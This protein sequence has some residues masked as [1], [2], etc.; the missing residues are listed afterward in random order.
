MQLSEDEVITNE[1]MLRKEK[2]I[3]YT[4]TDDD[5]IKLYGTTGDEVG[6]GGGGGDG[7]IGGPMG[8]PPPA[9]DELGGGE[10]GGETIGTGEG[11]P[12]EAPAGGTQ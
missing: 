5:L 3:P 6:F 10:L 1:S 8:G 12:P 2:G 4:G 7:G 9:G 11:P